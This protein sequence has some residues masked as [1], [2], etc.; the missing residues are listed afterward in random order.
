VAKI[1]AERLELCRAFLDDCYAGWSGEDIP[2]TANTVL[3][4]ED[5]GQQLTYCIMYF[6][7]YVGCWSRI[8]KA[9]EPPGTP[10]AK[11]L[12]SL[13]AGPLLCV[14]GWYFDRGPK[15]WS[16][17]TAV[18]AL[19]WSDVLDLESHHALL[20][21]ILGSVRVDYIHDV[22]VPDVMPPQCE[23]VN[24]NMDAFDIESIPDGATVLLPMLLNHMLGSSQPMDVVD[25]ASWFRKLEQRA[26]RIVI[27]DL[28]STARDTQGFWDSAKKAVKIKGEPSAFTFLEDSS[29]FSA[30]YPEAIY[31]RVPESERRT[32]I[33]WP[34]F[35]QVSGCVFERVKGWR[36]LRSARR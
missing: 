31:Q 4:Y 11:H 9:V 29:R 12:V 28:D 6:A 19:S 30:A 34:R 2:S 1:E 15:P 3:T 13:G 24:V 10:P 7:K 21:H 35:C 23:L 27:V 17:V 33:K 8:R 18:D 25:V 16:T 14:A 20:R 32:G 36:W 22:Y 5:H 26:G